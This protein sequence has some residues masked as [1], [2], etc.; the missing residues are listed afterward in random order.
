MLT[1]EQK[2]VVRYR[3]NRGADLIIELGFQDRI[4]LESMDVSSPWDCPASQV[5]LGD[6]LEG[7]RLL[8]IG[9]YMDALAHGLI[10]TESTPAADV[11]EEYTILTET[12][13][14]RLGGCR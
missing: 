11:V 7:M 4:D 13:R 14:E 2:Q 6:M 3:A 5:G 9:G 12:F 8:E 1:E 10:H